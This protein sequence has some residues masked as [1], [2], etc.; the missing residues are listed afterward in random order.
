M[1][2]MD[3]ACSI[4]RLRKNGLFGNPKLFACTS[5][6]KTGQR[7]TVDYHLEA[8]NYLQLQTKLIIAKIQSKATVVPHGQRLSKATHCFR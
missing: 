7:S 4:R 1:R 3:I 8:K 6:H 2:Q 5:E